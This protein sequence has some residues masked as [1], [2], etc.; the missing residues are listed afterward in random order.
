MP[1]VDQ[2]EKL[3]DDKY[4]LTPQR[5]A[6]LAALN[7]EL[8]LHPTAEDIYAQAK[9]YYSGIGLATVYRTLELLTELQILNPII[10]PKGSTR[11]EAAHRQHA[12]FICLNCGQIFDVDDG[13]SQFTNRVEKGA[14]FTVTS[15]SVQLFGYCHRCALEKK[16]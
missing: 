10:V 3:K 6:V 14:D 7:D 9:K 4:Q 8:A 1:L 11:Y 15:T 16:E 5:R 13:L 2:L 12:H